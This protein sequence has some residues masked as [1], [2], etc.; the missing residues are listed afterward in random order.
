MSQPDFRTAH[1]LWQ[2]GAKARF[3]GQNRRAPPGFVPKVEGWWLAGWDAADS[4]M[5]QLAASLAR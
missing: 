2:D 3:R 1:R 4:F 5:A